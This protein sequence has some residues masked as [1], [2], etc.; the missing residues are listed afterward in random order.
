MAED[1]DW[2]SLAGSEESSP[3]EMDEVGLRG[4][5]EVVVWCLVLVGTGFWTLLKA[6]ILGNDVLRSIGL[7]AVVGN[8]AVG[9]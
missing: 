6:L 9:K 4:G 1:W 7:E 2:K 5:L 8:V 3:L